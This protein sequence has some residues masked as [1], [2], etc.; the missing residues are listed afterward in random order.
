VLPLLRIC[1]VKDAYSG[2][3]QQMVGMRSCPGRDAARVNETLKARLNLLFYTSG[4]QLQTAL[5]EFIEFY[6]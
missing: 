6:N 3:H 2:H 4:E 5:G 1:E